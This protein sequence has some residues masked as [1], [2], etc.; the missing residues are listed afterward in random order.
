M[1]PSRN[2]RKDYMVKV[3]IDDLQ[4]S[5]IGENYIGKI[6]YRANRISN[7]STQWRYL[8]GRDRKEWNNER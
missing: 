8:Y 5:D 3:A 2:L 6:R 4:E 1:E 7:S